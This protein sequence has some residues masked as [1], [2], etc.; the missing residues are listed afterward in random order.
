VPAV[1]GCGSSSTGSPTSPSNLNAAPTPAG[2]G[3]QRFSAA[4]IALHFSYPS[5]LRPT[6]LA[7][8]RRVAGSTSNSTHAAVGV[9]PYD[10]LIVSHFPNL[11]I[12]VTAANIARLAPGI[13]QIFSQV[14]GR[15]MRGTI[16]TVG[17]LPALS[18]PPF[19][20]QG[21]PV[22]ATARVT[23]VFTGRNEY[24]LQCQSTPAH[25]AIIAQACA[26]MLATV[27]TTP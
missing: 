26:Q 22:A 12:S 19:A 27:S 15:A 11:G 4:G 1:A 5:A 25:R 6:P 23:N 16:G 7:P 10:L 20:V 21:L 18:F 24:E 14:A 2:A 8:S 3:Q 13:D 17:G 9:G